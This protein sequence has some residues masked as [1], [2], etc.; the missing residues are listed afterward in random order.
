MSSLRFRLLGVPRFERDGDPV[1]LTAAKA[2]ALL[3]YL[4]LADGPQPR[5]RLLGLLWAESAA[6]AARK[7]LRNIL[8]AI[9]RTLGDDVIRADNDRLSLLPGIW[10]DVREFQQHAKSELYAGPFLD[11]L[12]LSEAPEFELWVTMERE[13]LAQLHSRSLDA[14]AREH[15]AAGDWRQVIAAG[16]AALVHDSLQ[17]PIYR[18]LMEAHARLGERGEAL[19]QYDLL[20]AVLARELGVAPLP[21]TEAL[22]V[23][24]LGGAFDRSAPVE[25][26]DEARRAPAAALARRP[27]VAAPRFVGRKAELA[28]L[29]AELAAAVAGDA[30]VVLLTGD[31]G[32]GKSRLWREWSAALPGG[33]VALEARCL[34][35]TQALPFAPLVELFGSHA[36]TQ[37]L[38]RPGSP[39]AARVVGGGGPP[40]PGAAARVA[41][42]AGSRRP[43]T[44]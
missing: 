1:E 8:W 11:G 28:A 41:R 13:R 35:A 23:A 24:I 5:D 36:C 44:R 21:E 20:R 4:A 39:V 32:L 33:C 6:D 42:T 37:R 3:A 34:E 25:P 9:R 19:R 29:D 27:G 2:V 30:R 40:A 16:R 26:A 15:A 14:R 38:F 43:A 31:V 17:E 7:N 18:A 22:R 10:V 12:F